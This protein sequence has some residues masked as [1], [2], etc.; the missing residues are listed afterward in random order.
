MGAKLVPPLVESSHWIVAA[1]QFAGTV[2]S[3]TLK[4]ALAGSVTVW[5]D[6][7]VPIAG[8]AA[9]AAEV[10]VTLKEAVALFSWPSTA[11]HSTLVV[12]NGKVA[13]DAGTQFRDLT[14]ASGSVASTL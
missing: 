12:P 5:S 9:H 2:P 14:S 7:C 4:L 6:G 11:V 10:T 3:F 13:P 8:L 1:E